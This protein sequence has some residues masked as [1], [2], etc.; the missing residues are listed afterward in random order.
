VSCI[1][2]FR[3]ISFPVISKAFFVDGEATTMPTGCLMPE[4]KILLPTGW[5]LSD[6]FVIRIR[7]VPAIVTGLLIVMLFF[8]IW[9]KPISSRLAMWA[10]RR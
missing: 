2:W 7:V 10:M 8:S 9:T 1:S 4:K 3:G 5:Q 6:N